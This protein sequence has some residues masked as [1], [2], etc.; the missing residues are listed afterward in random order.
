SAAPAATIAEANELA[1]SGVARYV[2]VSGR[3]DSESDFE[4]A[5][6]RPLVFR[7]TRFQARLRGRWTDFDR[8]VEQVP[9]ELNEGLDTIRIDTSGL[10]EGLIVI[11]RETEG[12]IGDLPDHAPEDLARDLPARVVVEHVSSVEHAIVIGVPTLDADGT[13][14]MAA[15]LGR[16]LILTTLEQP[17][18]MRILTEGSSARPRLAAGLLIVAVVFVAIGLLMLALPGSAL[19]ASPDPTAIAGSDTRSGGEGP[20]IVGAP[21]VAMIVVVA[22][23][24]LTTLIVLA[25]VRLTRDPRPGDEGS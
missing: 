21:L 13:A 18:A 5:D 22:I 23:G 4:D 25:Y 11:P 10:A 16:P 20:G 6:H 2:R 1:R 8:V 19:A 14:R 15:G 3:I 9:F 12:L 17:E 24:M 7:Q